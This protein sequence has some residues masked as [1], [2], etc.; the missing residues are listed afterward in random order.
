VTGLPGVGKTH[1]ARAVLDTVPDGLF[2]PVAVGGS[3]A[4]GDAVLTSLAGRRTL[5]VSPAQ[6]LWESFAGRRAVVVLD[7][8][9]HASDLAPAVAE[10]CAGYPPLVLVLTAAR[11]TRVPGERVLALRPLPVPRADAGPEHP[12]VSLFAQ[13]AAEVGIG[14]D[15][16]DEQVRSEVIKVCR[17]TGGLPLAVELAA[18]RTVTQP[19]RFIERTLWRHRGD[20]DH[21]RRHDRLRQS[22]GS[23][24]SMVSQ[25]AR[26]AVAQCALFAGPFLLDAAGAVIELPEPDEDVYDALS[27]LVD[28][29]LLEFDTD[30]DEPATGTRFV[31]RDPVRAFAL[32]QLGSRDLDAARRRHANYFRDRCRAGT[33]VAAREWP[34]I[35]QALDFTLRHG[36]V[37][38]PLIV[39]AAASPALRR[40]AGVGA[41]LRASLDRLA[42]AGPDGSPGKARP[43]PE[44]RS[45]AM[46]W[47]TVLFPI[48]ADDLATVG[49]WTAQRLAEATALARESG[50]APA[51]LEALET[52]VRSL[53][54]TLDLPAAAAAVHEGLELAR[55]LD[56]QRAMARF[57]AWCA[58]ET[59]MRGNV[60]ETVRLASAALTRG[61]AHVEPIAVI[62]AA[63]MLLLVPEPMRPRF[64]PPIPDLRA[65]LEMCE[66]AAQ[67]YVGMIILGDLSRQDTA[68]GELTVAARWAWRQ[69]MVAADRIHSEPLSTAFGVVNTVAIALRAGD[70][71]A[72]IRLRESVRS[73]EFLLP[74]YMPPVLARAYAEDCAQLENSV[75]GQRY[76][77]LAAEVAGSTMTEANR[78]AQAWAR[79]LA[80]RAEPERPRAEPRPVA[81]LTARERQVLAGLASGATNR[82]IAAE[83]GVSP[84]TVMHHSVAIYRKLGVRGRA[85]ATAWAVRAGLR[86]E[87]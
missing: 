38:D 85:A 12:T 68:R 86:G 17:R 4:V 84:K 40:L 10:L 43:D 39:G 67:P 28:A 31:M 56:D 70:V 61:R 53:N 73:L 66:Q 13:R 78:A 72:A 5:T 41:H 79:E 59:Q 54:V 29:Y 49:L 23:A 82:E 9:D 35:A 27:E 26:V 33:D 1:L 44:L 14:V 80:F 25:A 19:L 42:E 30:S 50:D 81:P 87:A 48:H 60:T 75:T 64:D 22:L 21:Q 6:A 18:A 32:D 37:D 65:L 3:H 34:D 58:M 16:S 83:L 20:A 62:W 55:A 52:T 63:R 77:Q 7:D 2:V 11:P 69:L 74:T 47:S 51:L 71:E 24:L 45:R 36:I 76:A 15:T 57:E 46:L 8:A